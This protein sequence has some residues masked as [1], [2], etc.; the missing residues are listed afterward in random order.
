M[1][2]SKKPILYV[3]AN[4]PCCREALAF[5]SSQGVDLEIRDVSANETDMNAMVSISGQTKTPTF[6]YEDFVVADFTVD[7]FFAE[8]SEFPEIVQRLGIKND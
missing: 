3:E 7:E 4:C 2:T 8:L 1:K 5:F 6:E